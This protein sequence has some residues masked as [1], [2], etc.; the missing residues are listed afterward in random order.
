MK[1]NRNYG[2]C[3]H[4]LWWTLRSRLSFK[5]DAIDYRKNRSWLFRY[6]S[7]AYVH[8]KLEGEKERESTKYAIRANSFMGKLHIWSLSFTPYFNLVPKFSIVLIWSLTSHWRVNLV[9]SF[10]S[11]MKIVDMTNDH[12]KKIS[13]HWCGNKL[14]FYFSRLSCY[15]FSFKDN[16]RD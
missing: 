13:F 1:H 7:H 9:T 2:K 5:L 4:A 15:Q 6:T 10:I 11:W 3:L 14:N 8:S 12:N 16:G